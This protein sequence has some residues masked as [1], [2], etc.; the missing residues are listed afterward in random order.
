ML[1]SEMH[2]LFQVQ[3]VFL[4]HQEPVVRMFMKKV[5]SGHK[6]ESKT[7]HS[8]DLGRVILHEL[9]LGESWDWKPAWNMWEWPAMM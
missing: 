7:G 9:S 3:S 5:T 8:A 4:R 2:H 1:G 6:T